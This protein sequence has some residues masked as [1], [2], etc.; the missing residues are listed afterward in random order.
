MGVAGPLVEPLVL[1]PAVL[2]LPSAMGNL[3]RGVTV[4]ESVDRGES[5]SGDCLVGA[6]DFDVRKDPACGGGSRAGRCECSCEAELGHLNGKVRKLEDIVSG[7][8]AASFK[9]LLVHSI[10]G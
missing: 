2:V 3:S 5:E 4:S 9:L 7:A 10:E 1:F 8:R 6:T